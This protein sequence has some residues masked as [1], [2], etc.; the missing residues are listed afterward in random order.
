MRRYVK[1][2]IFE[3]YRLFFLRKPMQGVLQAGRRKLISAKPDAPLLTNLPTGAI[4]TLTIQGA[5]AHAG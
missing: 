5:L 1:N 4:L 3:K 2:A